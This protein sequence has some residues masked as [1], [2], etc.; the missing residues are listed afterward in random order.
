MREADEEMLAAM[1]RCLGCV[2]ACDY[3]GSCLQGASLCVSDGDD[4]YED[5]EA[6]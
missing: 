5:G 2:G 6:E 3:T 4:E 1:E